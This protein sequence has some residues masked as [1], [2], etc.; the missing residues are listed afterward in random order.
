MQAGH[1]GQ[2]RQMTAAIRREMGVAQWTLLL[3]LGFIWGLSFFFNAIAVKALSPV[4]IVAL[5][6]L[7]ATVALWAVAFALGYRPPSTLERWRDLLVM[8][9][10]NNIVPFT[11]IVWGQMEIASGLASILN[12]TT[13][14]FTLLIANWFTRDEPLT[15]NRLAGVAVGLAGVAVMVGIGAL[16]DLGAHVLAQLAV[17]GA[18]LSYGFAGSWGRRL[19][20]NPPIVTAAG[21]TLCSGLMLAPVTLATGGFD[22]LMGASPAVLGAILGLGLLCTAIA[23][24]MFFS[25]LKSSGAGNV[26]L[27]TFIVPVSAILLGAVFLGERLE[28]QHL[29]GMAAIA[30]GLIDGRLLRIGRRDPTFEGEAHRSQ[31]RRP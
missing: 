10:I 8:G 30:A 18:A 28:P 17:L 6:C 15:A 1:Q 11:L 9:V 14:F 19:A 4:G 16:N 26:S 20:V 23:Y 13:P 25:I 7:I 29:L 31:R 21:Q 3:S 2:D 27:V 12:A 22:G 5:R 24:V